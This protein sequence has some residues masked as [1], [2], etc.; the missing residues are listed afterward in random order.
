MK[1]ITRQLHYA[2]YVLFAWIK[3][4]LFVMG[5]MLDVLVVW[6]LQL[7]SLQMMKP[8]ESIKPWGSGNAT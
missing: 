7:I 2:F 5:I 6:P 3:V 1:Y 8:W 4:F